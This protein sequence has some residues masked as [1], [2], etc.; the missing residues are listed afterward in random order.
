MQ[1]AFSFIDDLHGSPNVKM[2]MKKQCIELYHLVATAHENC[3][4][5]CVGAFLNDEH[6]VARCT[7]R[8]LTYDAS[9]SK[10]DFSEVFKSRNDSSLRGNGN[11]LYIGSVTRYF[12]YDVRNLL[13][14]RDLQPIAQQVAHFA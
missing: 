4:S 2:G 8:D 11:E 7:E 9:F 1:R 6:L 14:F 5:A 10:L 12:G 3:D 13:R